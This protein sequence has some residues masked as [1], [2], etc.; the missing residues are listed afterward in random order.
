MSSVQAI[1]RYKLI[2]DVLKMLLDSS[3]ELTWT[4]LP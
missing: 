4:V 1:V 3:I 2:E